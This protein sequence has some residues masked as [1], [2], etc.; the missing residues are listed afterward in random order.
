MLS[1]RISLSGLFFTMLAL[2]AQFVVATAMPPRAAANPIHRISSLICYDDEADGAGV[3]APAHRHDSSDCVLCPLCFV[4]ASNAALLV[5]AGPEVPE[6]GRIVM[7]RAAVLPPL[8]AP[9][10][11][12]RADA[13]PRAPPPS[14]A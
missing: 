7:P 1:R 2:A 4:S 5:P 3:P 14:R 12:L 11:V 10:A 9:P 13:Q 6:P 8:R